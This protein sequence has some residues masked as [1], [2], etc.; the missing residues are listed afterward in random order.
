MTRTLSLKFRFYSFVCIALLT[1]VHAYNLENS[2]LTP[3]TFVSEPLTFTSYVEYL[4][5]NGLLRFRLPILF[6]ISGFLFAYQDNRSFSAQIKKRFETLLVPLFLW[7][8]LSLSFTFLLQRFS[9]TADIVYRAEIDQQGQNIPYE[10]LSWWGIVSRWLLTP[11]AFQLWFIRSLFFYNLFYPAIRWIV[12]KGYL[13]TIVPIALFLWEINFNLIIDGQGLL[14]FSL[15]VWLQKN[16]FSLERKP[17]WLDI[18]F[19]AIL[20]FGVNIIKTFMAFELAEYATV[21]PLQIVFHLLYYISVFTGVLTVWYGADAIVYKCMRNKHFVAASQ[22]SFFIYGFHVPFLVYLSVWL[23]DV[24]Q[25][26]IYKRII[27]YFL[28]AVITIGIALL[29]A[30]LLRKLTPKFY[31][32]LTGGRG[33]G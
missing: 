9:Y 3:S 30:I 7:S 28:A 16:N 32:V 5:A 8:L 22:F 23:L 27:V 1:L 10:N 24:L 33:L 25:G 6:I 12:V 31:K 11:P 4:L 13:W 2:Y 15:G 18:P 26:F 17:K 29:I 14:F 19:V 20:Y 21:I